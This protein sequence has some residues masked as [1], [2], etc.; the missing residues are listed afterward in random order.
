M[1]RIWRN[2]M[3]SWKQHRKPPSRTTDD[4][5]A[6]TL[7]TL[8]SPTMGVA[9]TP[10]TRVSS[11]RVLTPSWQITLDLVKDHRYNS[12]LRSTGYLGKK[13]GEKETFT[14]EL[15][16]GHISWPVT[17]VTRHSADQWPA[18]PVTHDPVPDRGMSRTR[19]LTNNDELTTIAFSAAVSFLQS[20]IH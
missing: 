20:L 18:W 1:Q 12:E 8:H 19:L 3:W 6:H 10:H 7:T 4:P 17:H 16:T 11:R 15:T 5:R 9:N 14:A 2:K 13:F